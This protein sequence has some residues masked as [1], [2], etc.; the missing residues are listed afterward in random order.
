[1][2]GVPIDL[3]VDE[4]DGEWGRATATFSGDRTYRYELTRVWGDGAPADLRLVNFVMLNPSTADAFAL[5][6][7]N[8]RCVGF[9]RDW[10]Y[11]GLVTTNV[12]ALRSTDPSGLRGVEDPVGPANDE[13]ILR[14][15]RSSAL[16]VAAWGVHATLGDRERVVLDRLHDAGIELHAL[17][18]TRG[19][20]PG[21]PLYVPAATRAMV[22]L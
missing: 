10:G 9:A 20:H 12:F 13:A 15:A 6:P 19:G 21:H 8:R 17:R 11:D 22:W 7:T 18:L 1:M 16:V 14:A 5:D 3:L 4:A 2:S